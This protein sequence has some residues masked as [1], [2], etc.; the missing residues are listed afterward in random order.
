MPPADSRSPTRGTRRAALYRRSTFPEAPRR[1]ARRSP[2]PSKTGQRASHGTAVCCVGECGAGAS[3]PLPR[4]LGKLHARRWPPRP[5]PPTARPDRTCGGARLTGVLGRGFARRRAL[6]AAPPPAWTIC[7]Q[8]PRSPSPRRAQGPMPIHGSLHRR[9]G[10]KSGA[11]RATREGAI[12]D[13][14][15]VLRAMPLFPARARLTG[16][17]PSV[18]R[19]SRS[20]LARGHLVHVLPSAS[21]TEMSATERAWTALDT[22]NARICRM[23]SRQKRRYLQ[24]DSPRIQSRAFVQ[25]ANMCSDLRKCGAA[26]ESGCTPGTARPVRQRRRRGDGVRRR[27]CALL[28]HPP[29][30]PRRPPLRPCPADHAV[31][32]S[33]P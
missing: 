27:G 12:D 16:G 4:A 32:V 29:Q 30:G 26:D 28:A 6:A 22:L 20:R 17:A 24:L 10:C 33:R 11:F 23:D 13:C 31:H 7:G 21:G 2:P 25:S 8:A 19:F 1:L 5:T 15:D 14:L 3:S 18:L 9:T